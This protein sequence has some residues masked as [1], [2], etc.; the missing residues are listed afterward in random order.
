YEMFMGPLEQ[1]KPWDMRGLKGIERFLD[2]IWRLFCGEGKGLSEAVVD[3]EPE[4]ELEEELHKTIESVTE[5]TEDLRFNTAI[6]S[7]MEFVNYLYKHNREQVPCEVVETM[8]I[9]L[10]PYAPHIAEEM[11]ER[12]GGEGSVARTE[13]PEWDEELTTEATV[14]IGVQVDGKTRG[15]IDVPKDAEQE[16]AVE[17]A[18]QNEDVARHLD[19]QD[20]ER[21]V[22]VPE[23]ILNFVLA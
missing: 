23:Q 7:M 3:D 10:S 6:A 8:T 20:V 5:D 12:L 16:E 17:L 14:E 1:D 2:R 13:W 21:V 19:G 9:M 11:W 22:Y 15:N 4:G 18:R